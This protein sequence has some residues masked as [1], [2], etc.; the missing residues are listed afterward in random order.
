MNKILRKLLW[1]CAFVVMG[2]A[3]TA[4]SD[5]ETTS[6]DPL[7]PSMAVSAEGLTWN[8]GEITVTVNDIVEYY[9]LVKPAGEAAAT[10]SE[11]V[12]NG[13]K[14]QGPNSV[15]KQTV[16]GLAATTDYTVYV[17]GYC[18]H[19]NLDFQS[20][21]YGEV[22]SANFTTPYYHED[23]TMLEVYSDGFK[24]HIKMPEGVDGTNAVVKW[25]V[26]N[27]VIY[28]YQGQSE[29]AF[30]N[31]NDDYWKLAILTEDTV[32]DINEE[33]RRANG[34]VDE[35]D[36]S[37]TSYFWEFIAPGEPLYLVLCKYT[38]AESLWGWGEGWYNSGFDEESYQN[39][40]MDYQWGMT[41]EMPNEADYWLEGSW[42]HKVAVKTQEPVAYEES[43]KVNVTNLT[44]TNATI[45]FIPTENC[46]SY[47]F[48]LFDDTMYDQI[49]N[50][51]DGDES[52]LQWFTTSY[53]GMMLAGSM[54]FYG[55][56]MPP[57]I[58]L[59]EFFY[60]VA[61]GNKYHIVCVAMDGK[62]EEDE[63]GDMMPVANPM[64]QNFIHETITMPDFTLDPC[65]ITVTALEPNSP[66][67]VRFNVKNTGSEK[68][69]AGSY[70]MNYVRDFE[71]EL[72]YGAT[73]TQICLDNYD[74]GYASFSEGELEQ[75]NS[76]EGYVMEFESRENAESR[77]AVLGFNAE[78]RPSNPDSEDCI[79]WADAWSGVQPDAERIESPYFESLAGSWTATATIQYEEYDYDTWSYVGKTAEMSSNV[80]IGDSEIPATLTDEV[81]AIFEEAGVSKEETDA[82][83]A[84]LKEQNANFNARTRGQNRIL[85][86]GWGFDSNYVKNPNYK[87]SAMRAATP[88]DLFINNEGYAASSTDILFY[89][90][91]P[92][93]FLQVDEAQNLF[94]PVNMNRMAPLTSW[95]D[96]QQYYLTSGNYDAGIADY[97]VSNPANMDDVS[98][99]PNIPVEVSA[100]GNTIT[101]KART[102][103]TDMGETVE[104]YPTVVYNSQYYGLSFYNTAIISEVVL[105]RNTTAAS[106]ETVDVA[107]LRAYAKAAAAQ[108][109]AVKVKE[110][111][112]VAPMQYTM[113]G[114]TPFT[115]KEGKAVTFQKIEKKAVTPEQ[116]K[117]NLLKLRQGKL[118]VRK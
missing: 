118:E 91:G 99:W 82:Y 9:Y 114:R 10:E 37:Y 58:N 55:T 74:Y 106:E 35:W 84:E 8:S 79:G 92:K 4:C 25:G 40:M 7:A 108:K 68:M 23:V 69:V 48:M 85:C 70:A 54:T 3:F 111:G 6:L 100:D 88:W 14:V 90:F 29:A 64:K 61:P 67:T 83:F 56:E 12:T 53:V 78:G 50:I 94:V 113:K 39:A 28:N 2:A 105:T 110:N 60:G 44:P 101:L 15:T 49:L 46:F 93:W 80:T 45:S 87:Y 97:T 75:I 73:Y 36:P 104:L 52:L 32:L 1:M 31:L 76:A 30:T 98:K 17:T 27:S 77:L 65:Q 5:D 33:T 41:D 62:L 16:T 66:W 86:T 107:A 116:F 72:S 81:Y 63:Y 103:K 42:H 22:V 71:V 26:T 47:T 38:W 13:T 117:E 96:G 59:A 115:K 21:P 19:R 95:M 112:E 24:A 18:A 51:L 20:V 11:V 89:E 34:I 57:M 43:V 109:N 102:V